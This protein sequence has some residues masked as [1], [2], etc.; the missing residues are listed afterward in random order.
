MGLRPSSASTANLAMHSKARLN[1]SQRISQSLIV[2]RMRE[3]CLLI[4]V[5]AVLV[6][7]TN[8]PV[9]YAAENSGGNL[10]WISTEPAEVFRHK[11]NREAELEAHGVE[12]PVGN[13]SWREYWAKVI[14]YYTN[15]NEIGSRR[16]IAAYVVQQRRAH[17]LPPL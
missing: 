2:G 17:G 16:E 8:A 4:S 3:F 15:A 5:I 6:G 13:A 14:E 9:E 11:V 7:C 10:H 1:S 12:P